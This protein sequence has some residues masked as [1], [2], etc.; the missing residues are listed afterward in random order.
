[1]RGVRSLICDSAVLLFARETVIV[2][3]V[4]CA[5]LFVL[6]NEEDCVTGG[7]DDV[8]SCKAIT[9]KD[10]CDYLISNGDDDLRLY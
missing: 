5:A 2:V 8:K 6:E 4:A 7:G 3:Y 10:R 9:E 1:M